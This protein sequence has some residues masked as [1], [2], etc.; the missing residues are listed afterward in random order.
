MTALT[1][2]PDV[3]V[4]PGVYFASS[5]TLIGDAMW[6][7]I[8]TDSAFGGRRFAYQ[9]YPVGDLPLWREQDR[10]PAFDL[11]KHT[12]GL[13]VGLAKIY[14]ENAVAIKEALVGFRL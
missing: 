7:V 4:E 1:A 14:A 5:A 11:D 9:W 6:R 12:L 8:V 10:W 2:F 3:E 13:P